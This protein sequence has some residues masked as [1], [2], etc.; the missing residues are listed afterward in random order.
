M[1]V[2]SSIN[3]LEQILTAQVFTYS[4]SSQGQGTNRPAIVM[5]RTH[6]P[7]EILAKYLDDKIGLENV[8]RLLEIRSNAIWGFIHMRHD[9]QH[10]PCHLWQ[11]RTQE[12]SVFEREPVHYL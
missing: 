9:S 12:V 7:L 4:C 8:F 10:N 11:P 5:A 2:Q 6:T 1:L 3:M